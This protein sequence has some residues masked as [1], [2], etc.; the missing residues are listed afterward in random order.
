MS[1]FVSQIFQF[2]A[3]TRTQYNL[4]CRGNFVHRHHRVCKY[5][6]VKCIIIES[7]RTDT[8]VSISIFAFDIY[9]HICHLSSL[10][11]CHIYGGYKI[12]ANNIM[13]EEMRNWQIFISLLCLSHIQ[14]VRLHVILFH[15]FLFLP[16]FIFLASFH[17]TCREFY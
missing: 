14:R 9:L 2:S 7:E 1:L 17:V 15:R 5:K 6:C 8:S 12:S 10:Y 11:L 13:Y 16:F 4:I 3:E